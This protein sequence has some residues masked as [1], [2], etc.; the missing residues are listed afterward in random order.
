MIVTPISKNAPRFE[1]QGRVYVYRYGYQ[2]LDDNTVIA[3]V[4]ESITKLPLEKIK[5]QVLK[6]NSANNINEI[7]DP[8]AYGF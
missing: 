2:T 5:T 6:Y 8:S 1:K 7:F 4:E 3:C